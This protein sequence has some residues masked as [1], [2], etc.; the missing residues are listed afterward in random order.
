MKI[1]LFELLQQ[2]QD[3][4][5]KSEHWQQSQDLKPLADH[6]NDRPDHKPEME[7]FH[8][9]PTDYSHS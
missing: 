6:V 8:H 9:L 1:W 4:K 5:T 3:H 7:L 2:S